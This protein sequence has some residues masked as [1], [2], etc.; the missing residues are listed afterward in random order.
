MTR[1]LPVLAVVTFLVAC[2]PQQEDK[3]S[4]EPVVDEQTFQEV[5]AQTHTD[6]PNS[7]AE[8]IVN[9][10]LLAPDDLREF[11]KWPVKTYLSDF[12]NIQNK[13]QPEA[14]RA[15]NTQ[16]II[17]STKEMLKK[18][19][20]EAVVSLRQAESAQ[21]AAQLLQEMSQLYA[22][23][24][25]QLAKQEQTAVWTAPLP[26]PD[27]RISRSYL[28]QRAR[29]L[30]KRVKEEYG[31]V[32]ALQST[33]VINKAV[34]DTWLAISS[35]QEPSVVS[36]AL[37]QTL[38]QADESFGTILQEYAD[39]ILSLSPR[40]IASL[41]VRLISSHQEIE[42]RMEALYGKE[43]VLKSRKMF[44][45]YLK[46]VDDI[47]QTPQRLKQAQQKLNQLGETYRR[48]MTDFQTQLN[49]GANSSLM[50]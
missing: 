13:A 41:R 50:R 42:K 33:P 12:L 16:R 28:Q 1:Y 29:E 26:S 19:R 9:G 15:A 27:D 49:E 31:E 43:A 21:Q 11:L 40:Q 8:A 20:R 2:S 25:S 45:P 47:F 6:F 23:G 10:P 24:F 7:R 48:E 5:P 44:E 32:C 36:K 30:L 3:I 46:G 38:Q 22:Q 17:Q 34:D 14:I 37:A 35:S 4:T 18:L 39:P